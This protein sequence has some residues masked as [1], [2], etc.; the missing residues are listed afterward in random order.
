MLDVVE[1]TIEEFEDNIYSHYIELFPKDEQREWKNIT[2]TYNLGIEK[3]YKIVLD[4]ETIGFFLLEKIKDY[5]YYV[6]YFAIY[7]KYQNKG[8]GFEAF[9]KLIDKYKD[10]GVIGEIEEVKDDNLITVRRFEF[11]KRLGFRKIGSLYYLYNVLYEPIV[12]NCNLDKEA[13]D[14]IFMDY[15]ITNCGEEEINKNGKFIK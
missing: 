6:D 5:P 8:Y 3:F 10:I 12:V 15:Y 1:I 4:N 7:K 2:K 13:I 11:Y 14:K 9:S